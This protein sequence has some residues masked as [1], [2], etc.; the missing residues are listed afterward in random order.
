MLDRIKLSAKNNWKDDKGRIYIIFP[1]KE[2]QQI[3]GCS[4]RT[5]TSA[6]RE[7]D[8]DKGVGLICRKKQGFSDPDIIYVLDCTTSISQG[9]HGQNAL[10]SETKK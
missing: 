2:I 1:Q 4:L 5:V 9:G 3:L 10:W 7:L 8:V 6:L